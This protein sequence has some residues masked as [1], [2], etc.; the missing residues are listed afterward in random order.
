MPPLRLMTVTV[1]RAGLAVAFLAENTGMLP[2][3]LA[4]ARLGGE[5]APP[6]AALGCVA[7]A[8]LAAGEPTT[9][10]T[11]DGGLAEETGGRAPGPELTELMDASAARN[12]AASLPGSW[13]MI[14]LH[15]RAAAVRYGP[16]ARQDYRSIAA[17]LWQAGVVRGVRAQLTPLLVA[18]SHRSPTKPRPNKQVPANVFRHA[19]KGS[20]TSRDWLR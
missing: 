5:Y 9:G 7:A 4:L 17:A 14:A 8:E 11:T 2:S 1:G 18:Y 3:C 10:A 19:A 16:G 15:T 20:A 12:G 6:L 13:A